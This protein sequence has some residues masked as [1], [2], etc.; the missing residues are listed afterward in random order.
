MNNVKSAELALGY[1][2]A[3][4]VFSEICIRYKKELKEFDKVEVYTSR[5]QL[6]FDTELRKNGES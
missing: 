4:N 3:G 1:V 5:N 6:G 2:P